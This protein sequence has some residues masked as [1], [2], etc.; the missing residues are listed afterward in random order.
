M[1]GNWY[2]AVIRRPLAFDTSPTEYKLAPFLEAAC[3]RDSTTAAVL[4]TLGVLSVG[5]VEPVT[6]PRPFNYELMVL[7][8]L[9]FGRGALRLSP[10]SFGG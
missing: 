8:N 2:S 5:L 7:F 1:K 3:F 6:G 9:Y 4:M 10:T